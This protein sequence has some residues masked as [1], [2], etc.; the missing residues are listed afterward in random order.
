[1]VQTFLRTHGTSVVPS[2][3]PSTARAPT[4]GKVDAVQLFAAVEFEKIPLFADNFRDKP[5]GIVAARATPDRPHRTTTTAIPRRT[6]RCRDAVG[7]CG[8]PA[9]RPRKPTGRVRL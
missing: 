2:V 4:R 1:M 3:C 6:A 9:R 8:R 5:G 7:V